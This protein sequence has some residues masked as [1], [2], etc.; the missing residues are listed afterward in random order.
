MKNGT[1]IVYVIESR[2][3]A[4]SP[5]NKP[6][7]PIKPMAKPWEWGRY[8]TF[9]AAIVQWKDQHPRHKLAF[10]EWHKAHHDCQVHGFFTL[11]FAVE[12]LERCK[13]AQSEGMG[14]DRHQG[15]LFQRTRYEFRLMRYVTTYKRE[16]TPI[17]EEDL[18]TALT[19]RRKSA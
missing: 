4:E 5:H 14:H 10:D 17:S 7:Q 1:H 12:A 19:R 8:N 9:D 11:R 6:D 3:V 15:H 2:R 18:V 13:K 16:I